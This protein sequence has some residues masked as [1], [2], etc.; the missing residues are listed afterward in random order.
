[1][2]YTVNSHNVICQLYL[3]KAGGE[4]SVRKTVGAQWIFVEWMDEKKNG[5]GEK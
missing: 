3:I 4:N 5:E 1:M 2:L